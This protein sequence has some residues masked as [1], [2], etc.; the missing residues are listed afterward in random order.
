M[1]FRTPLA[2]TATVACL[3]GI[4]MAQ[5][6]KVIPTVAGLDEGNDITTRLF[7]RTAFRVQQIIDAAA[8]AGTSASL[9]A[10]GYRSDNDNSI[11]S[12]AFNFPAVTIALSHTTISPT[13]MSTTFA[14]NITGTP[15]TVFAGAVNAPAYT[16]VAG[17]ISPFFSIPISAFAY[18][19]A[20]GNLLID[21]VATDPMPAS[22]NRSTDGALPGGQAR[23]VG[24]SGQTSG[25]FDNL[26][27]LVAGNGPTQG[28]FSG[29]VPGGS[30]VL[31]VQAAR[32]FSGLLW[33]GGEFPTPIDLTSFGMPGNVAYVNPLATVPFTMTSG[34]GGFRASWTLNVPGNPGTALGQI[35][36][37]A[38]VVDSPANMLGVVATNGQ[39]M[40][41][42]DPLPHALNQ[43]NSNDPTAATGT[44]NYV[45]GILGGAVTQLFG[46]FQ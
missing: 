5:T 30:F 3:A 12:V 1:N 28:R 44:L 36:A 46:T 37:Q 15:T 21:V 7:A 13:A 40:I 18:T 14:S 38:F 22:L 19:A 32:G 41:I 25:A 16:S 10:V 23:V 45:S 39:R 8:V 17:G 31:F 2:V 20:T 27:L 6:S 42:G 34:I 26:R 35:S 11:G 33:L 4:T 29:M 24:Q 43:L 9:T